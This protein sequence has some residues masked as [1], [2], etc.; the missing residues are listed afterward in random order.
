MCAERVWSSCSQDSIDLIQGE[1][2]EH[3][4]KDVLTLTVT[5]R[6]QRVNREMKMLVENTEDQTKADPG[7][8]R[9]VV[10]AHDIQERVMRTAS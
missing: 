2:S 1:R 5:A 4:A 9:I 8:L 10:R 6:L 7:L 3:E